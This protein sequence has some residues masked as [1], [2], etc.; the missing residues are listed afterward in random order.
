M[1]GRITGE[2]KKFQQ[3]GKDGKGLGQGD[4]AAGWQ[5][6]EEVEEMGE[7]KKKK[8]ND[9]VL[10]HLKDEVNIRKKEGRR[11]KGEGR[12]RVGRWL[13]SSKLYRKESGTEQRK[14]K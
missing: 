14:Y 8:I 11:K 6:E 4:C 3:T 9:K 10:E 1:D 12:K 13:I 2:S 7:K 5:G